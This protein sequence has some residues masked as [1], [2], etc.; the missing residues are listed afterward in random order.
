MVTKATLSAE[1]SVIG[2]LLIDPSITGELL[3]LT[4]AE[5]FCIPELLTIYKAAAKLFTSGKAV[6][7]VMIRNECGEEYNRLMLECMEVVPSALEWRGYVTVMQE[8]TRVTRIRALA[9][10]LEDIKT[11][12][13]GREI[14]QKANKILSVNNH[15]KIVTMSEAEKEFVLDQIEQKQFISYGLKK[16]DVQLYSDYGDFV[17]LSGRPS[18]GKTALALQMAAHMARS[19]RV[20][21]YSLE[22]STKKLTNRLIANQCIIDFGHINRREMTSDEWERESKKR[23]Q[24]TQLQLDLIPASGWS[25][26]EIISTALSQNHRIIFIDYLQLIRGQGKNR[27]E[28]VT[29]VS[30]DLHTAAQDN[31]ILVV[32]LAQLNRAVENRTEQEPTMTDLRESGQIEQ[33]ADAILA[34][35]LHPDDDAPANAR[36]LRVLKNKEGTL[37][38]FS[39]AFDGANQMFT[40]FYPGQ[41]ALARQINRLEENKN[42]QHKKRT[43]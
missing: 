27:I 18:A 30:M 37:G 32:A 12:A 42:G 8:Q 41:L 3:H 33:D 15:T 10:S 5:D 7:A 43:S 36:R 35:Y 17:V 11:S 1:Y 38:N 31:E 24:L 34:L 25:V 16:L 26:D 4:R 21:F 40:E 6:D 13:E 22:T 23:G 29:N 39:L 9:K 2:C 28:Q 20:G 14:F 19:E